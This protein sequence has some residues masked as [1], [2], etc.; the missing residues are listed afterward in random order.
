MKETVMAII[1]QVNP[2]SEATLDSDLLAEEVLDSLSILLLITELEKEYGFTWPE[3]ELKAENFVTVA[4][5][6]A[7]VERARP[8]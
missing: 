4:A 8:A 6:C 1:R 2:Y 3:E 7:L 5:I